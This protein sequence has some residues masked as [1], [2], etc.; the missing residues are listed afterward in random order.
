MAATTQAQVLV[1]SFP[2]Y[3]SQDLFLEILLPVAAPH[4]AVE[5]PLSCNSRILCLKAPDV[6]FGVWGLGFGVWVWGLGFGFGVWGLGFG[7]W[8]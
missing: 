4:N 8:G 3:G 7:V 1:R 6:G 2:A 5:M